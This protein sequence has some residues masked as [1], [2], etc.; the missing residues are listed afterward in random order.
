MAV[1]AAQGYLSRRGTRVVVV[2][3]GS[4]ERT[5][6]ERENRYRDGETR[7]ANVPDRYYRVPDN[8]RDFCRRGS[9]SGDDGETFVAVFSA[10]ATAYDLSL[11][12]GHD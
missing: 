10:V 4:A 11:A 12:V 3:V 2:G 5:D 8:F 9:R 6:G 1:A 7:L